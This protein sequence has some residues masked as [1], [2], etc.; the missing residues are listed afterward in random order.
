[1]PAAEGVNYIKADDM[2]YHPT[3]YTK[4][5]KIAKYICVAS[6]AVAAVTC[7]VPK[8][9]EPANEEEFDLSMPLPLSP[10]PAPS[11][12]APP[13][14][15]LIENCAAQVE[16]R[17]KAV[18]KLLAA[19]YDDNNSLEG[20][21]QLQRKIAWAEDKLHEVIH[22]A[23]SSDG[24]PVDEASVDDLT[25]HAESISD[26]MSDRIVTDSIGSEGSAGED[27]ND[28][29]VEDISDGM[30]G[31]EVEVEDL[32]SSDIADD[33]DTDLRTSQQS[34]IGSLFSEI[35]DDLVSVA[36]TPSATNINRLDE[37]LQDL[38]ISEDL[39]LS[40]RSSRRDILTSLK[41]ML[42]DD[43]EDDISIDMLGFDSKSALIT[44][45]VDTLV[46]M[47]SVDTGT[48]L[49]R[50]SVIV[51]HSITSTPDFH[52]F[53]DTEHHDD[54]VLEEDIP[55]NL[56][57]IPDFTEEVVSVTDSIQT[58]KTRVVDEEEHLRMKVKKTERAMSMTP[59]SEVV[60][61]TE[62][63]EIDDDVESSVGTFTHDLSI[64]AD[65]VSIDDNVDDIASLVSSVKAASIPSEI[66]VVADEPVEAIVTDME[67]DPASAV[68]SEFPEDVESIRSEAGS[69]LCLLDSHHPWSSTSCETGTTHSSFSS[70]SRSPPRPRYR[71]NPITGKPFLAPHDDSRLDCPDE[72]YPHSDHETGYHRGHD[73]ASPHNPRRHRYKKKFKPRL[74]IEY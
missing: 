66:S 69:S 39:A 31:A 33:V 8:T 22:P 35:V 62:A 10:I 13:L 59:I 28:D 64:V 23:P 36:R 45:V 71:F 17:N 56:E 21:E 38:T 65:D 3:C 58:F 72:I 50:R 42:E 51:R 1:M 11:A 2:F 6:A 48:P 34:K 5:K 70:V 4:R 40:P 26:I 18:S 46:S 61:M 74:E 53:R 63:D 52:D 43:I 32:D 67:S 57:E 41:E 68:Q 9:P 20:E 47:D 29:M 7:D 24:A 14:L 37:I 25:H 60:V 30:L 49:I 19:V 12:T 55:E 16:Q 44:S 54:V 15:S 73:E 27:I